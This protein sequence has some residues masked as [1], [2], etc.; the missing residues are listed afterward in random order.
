MKGEFKENELD[1]SESHIIKIYL[2]LL[3]FCF[4]E[5]YTLINIIPKTHFSLIT[6]SLSSESSMHKIVFK[7]Q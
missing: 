3:A 2:F 5:H 7:I 6:H 4:S 1:G